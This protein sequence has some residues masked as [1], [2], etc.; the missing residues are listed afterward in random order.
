MKKGKIILISI[1]SIV[2]IIIAFTF[3]MLFT[4]KTFF[5]TT[6]V[7]VNKQEIFIPKYSY[8]KDECCMTVATFYSLKSEKSL[9]REIDNYMSDFEYFEDNSTYGYKKDDLFIQSYEVVDNGLYREI[10]IVY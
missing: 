2:I 6:Y 8:F 1:A 4:N 3:V 10:V 5:K 7:G 9:K